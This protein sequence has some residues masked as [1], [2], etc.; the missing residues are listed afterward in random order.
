MTFSHVLPRRPSQHL[1]SLSE[2]ELVN[3]ATKP[4]VIYARIFERIDST[5]TA[6][7]MPS[8]DVAFMMK[9]GVKD[10]RLARRAPVQR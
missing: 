6:H 2:T 9:S 4:R 7:V 1:E 3:S 5:C 8:K 10:S